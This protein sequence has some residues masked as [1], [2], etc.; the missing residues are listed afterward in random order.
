MVPESVQTYPE[1][2]GGGIEAIEADETPYDEDTSTLSNT[3]K[4]AS[5]DDFVRTLL[6]LPSSNTH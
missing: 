1:T 4:I 3:M 2:G 6:M 5:P